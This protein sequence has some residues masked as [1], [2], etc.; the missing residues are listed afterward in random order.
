MP[1]RVTVRD[2]TPE[3][4]PVVEGLF[5]PRGACGGCWCMHWRVSHGGA[6]WEQ[7]KG[8]RNRRE[9]KKLVTSGRAM[10]CLAFAGETPVGWC[11][12]GPR[13]DYPR[14]ERSRVLQTDAG[15]ETWA[16][17]CF[18]IPS[19]W[20]RRGVARKLLDGAVKLA[21]RH[22]ATSLEGYPVST[23]S[24]ADGKVPAAFAWTGVPALFEAAGFSPVERR[25]DERPVYRLSL[26][27]KA[28]RRATP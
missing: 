10:G 25:E 13:A 16:V 3:D 2:L 18:Y 24:Y 8:E 4:W 28:S 15:P 1:E 17:A 5:G 22:R 19:G 14:L 26:R 23:A 7:S 20:R 6:L 9:L 21:R 12:A 11:S 27:G